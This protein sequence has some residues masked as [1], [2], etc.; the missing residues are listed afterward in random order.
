MTKP[1]LKGV[2]VNTPK[3]PIITIYGDAGI[4][5]TSFAADAPHP[6]F[7][8]TEDGLGILKAET[9]PLCTT[10]AEFDSQLKTLCES[11]HDY[12]TLIIDS[13]DW[14]ETLIGEQV[15]K[16]HK[17]IT[18]SEID[19][20]KGFDQVRAKMHHIT[21]TLAWLRNNKNMIVILLAHSLVRKVEKPD[22]PPF[23]AHDLKLNRKVSSLIQEFSD[24]IFFADWE[25]VV[26]SD[27][28][29]Y[30]GKRTRA[31]GT[32]SRIMYAEGSPTHVAKNRFSLPA[33]LPLSWNSFMKAFTKH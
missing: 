24:I 3:P 2:T 20:G 30:G 29:G 32:G 12:Q 21:N 23:D 19:Y 5:K 25:M 28:T 1:K 17:K 7:I 13:L 9:F 8:R 27:D 4:G 22:F 31:M 14:L 15:A 6:I 18:V 16:D 10:I 33:K 26:T 11:D